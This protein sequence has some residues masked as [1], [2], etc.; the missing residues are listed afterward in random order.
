LQIAAPSTSQPITRGEVGAVD[1]EGFGGRVQVHAVAGLVLHLGQQ[2]GLPP[3]GRR[4]GD[5]PALGLH[6]DDLG[7]GVLG[8]LPDQ[9]VAIPVRHPVPR[10]D[11]PFGGDR[12]VEMLLKLGFA[13]TPV[14]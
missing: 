14:R 2:D 3:K 9:G 11:A 10:L 1:A 13:V 7:M 8:D 4:A 12:R 6:S 5:P